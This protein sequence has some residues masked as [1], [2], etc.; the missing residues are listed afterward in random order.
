MPAPVLNEQQF[1]LALKNRDFR[2]A[3]IAELQREKQRIVKA[4][5][6]EYPGQ[7]GCVLFIS[8]AASWFPDFRP[9]M[10]AS[11][12]SVIVLSRIS[13]QTLKQETHI[14]EVELRLLFLADA[15]FETKAANETAPQ[16]T[17]APQ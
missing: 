11:I 17:D 10:L 12:V 7:I 5:W 9:W 6:W 16:T 14:A 4:L 3:R 1:Q 8:V 2:Q 13:A 15:F